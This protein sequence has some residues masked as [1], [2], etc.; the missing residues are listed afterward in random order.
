MLLVVSAVAEELGP[1]EGEPLGIGAVAA[2]ARMA[3]L[4]SRAAPDGVVLLGTGGAYPAGPAIGE[5]CVARRVGMSSGVAAMGLGYVPR[6][7]ATLPCD[8]RL[9]GR[10]KLPWADV[11][12]VDAVTTDPVLAGRLGDRWTVEHTE[13]YGAAAAC[14]DAGV[15]FV[16]VLGIAWRAGPDANAQWLARRR[17]AQEAARQAV[18]PLLVGDSSEAR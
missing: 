7:A 8:P 10:L 9:L 2:A 18:G 16:A 6:A 15:P 1:L 3:R 13:A 11:L 14:A 17:E 5:A 4:L 12:T